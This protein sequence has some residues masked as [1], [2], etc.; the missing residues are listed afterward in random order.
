[1]YSDLTKR[2]MQIVAEH[3]HVGKIILHTG[4][5]GVAKRQSEMLK[6]D[7]LNMVS[8]LNTDVFIRGQLLPVMSGSSAIAPFAGTAHMAF[9]C[10]RCPLIEIY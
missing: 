7:F 5:D 8:S 9:N 1:M 10:L 2:I 4:T 6:D 3:S